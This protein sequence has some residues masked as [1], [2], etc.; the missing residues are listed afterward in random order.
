MEEMRRG[1]R[2]KERKTGRGVG[3]QGKGLGFRVEGLGF[4]VGPRFLGSTPWPEIR[5]VGL[6]SAPRAGLKSAPSA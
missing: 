2:E 3:F 1:G 5:A 6:K 4:R